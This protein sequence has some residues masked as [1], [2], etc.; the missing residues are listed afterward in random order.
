MYNSAQS[1]RPL[2]HQASSTISIITHSTRTKGLFRCDWGRSLLSMSLICFLRNIALPSWTFFSL[3]SSSTLAL[4]SLFKCAFLFKLP[5]GLSQLP[6]GGKFGN[7]VSN[8]RDSHVSLV[9]EVMDSWLY[10]G[11]TPAFST[12]WQLSVKFVMGLHAFYMHLIHLCIGR[13][14]KLYTYGRD[15]TIALANQMAVKCCPQPI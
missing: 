7:D 3:H 13:Y 6:W 11:W 2:I 8:N 9:C 5:F 1:R 10:V 4:E 14:A 15:L 12:M